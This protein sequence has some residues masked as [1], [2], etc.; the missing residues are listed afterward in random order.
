MVEDAIQDDLAISVLSFQAE[1]IDTKNA[2]AELGRQWTVIFSHNGQDVNIPQ[3][4]AIT[5]GLRGHNSHVWT[6]YGV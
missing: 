5:N 2:I 1:N 3:L 4:Q 6:D